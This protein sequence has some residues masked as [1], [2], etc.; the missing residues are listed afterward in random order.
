MASETTVG[1]IVGTLRLDADQFHREIERAIA[2]VD[3]LEGKHVDVKVKADTARA[4]AGLTAVQERADRLDRTNVKMAQSSTNAGRG[5]NALTAAILT[6]GPAIV[7]LAVAAVGLA[8]GFGAMGAAGVLAIV[9]IRHEMQQGTAV[10][11]A[12]SGELQ[13][14]KGDLNDLGAVAAGGVLGPF[15]AVVATLQ[16]QMS[17]LTRIIGDFASVTGKTA[18]NLTTGLIASFIAL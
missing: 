13:T 10:G 16:P 14:L 4:E 9:G 2:E 15:Q 5:M 1:G 17:N 3:H 12:Y 18:G 11:H 6:V 8:A 7:P